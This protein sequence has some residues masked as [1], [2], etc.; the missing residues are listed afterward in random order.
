VPEV[1][2][3]LVL[4]PEDQWKRW[5]QRWTWH[6]D[7]IPGLLDLMRAEAVSISAFD[8]QA[9]RVQTSRDGA[10]VPFRVEVIDAVDD[11]W[12]ALVQYADNVQD[13]V[14]APLAPLP[15]V[16]RWRAR[17]EVAG[18]R[19][20]ADVRRDAI[21][22]VGWLVDR[23]EWIAPLAQLGDT[24]DHLFAQVR[25]AHGQYGDPDRR[26]PTIPRS[27]ARRCMLCGA[28]AVRT[29]LWGGDVVS[30]CQDCGEVHRA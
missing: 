1:L 23:V 17:G 13:L 3:A 19:T 8:Y 24:E 20:T 29:Q 9:V 5:I 15:G 12:A 28:L 18:I 16:A 2:E 22:I 11:L 26:V 10:P 27:P 25:A 7:Q 14:P 21:V 4:T 30:R 6:L